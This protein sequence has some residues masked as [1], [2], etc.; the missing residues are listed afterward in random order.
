LKPIP[1]SETPE[2]LRFPPGV[3]YLLQ[4]FPGA[5]V[6]VKPRLSS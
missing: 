2:P 4:A 6:E 3:E 5:R 1:L